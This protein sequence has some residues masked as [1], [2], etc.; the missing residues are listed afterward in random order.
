MGIRIA[1]GAASGDVAGMVV[2]Q[3]M[4]LAMIGVAVGV[5]AALA[6][7]RVMQI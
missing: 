1:L 3:G 5:S 4:M 7:T 2:R 6:T